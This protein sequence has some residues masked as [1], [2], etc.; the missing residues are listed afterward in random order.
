MRIDQLTF[1]RFIAAIAIVVYH[2]GAA[3]APF[4]FTA[5]SFLFK[6]ANLGV[7][8]FYVLSGFVMMLAYTDKAPINAKLFLWNRLARIYPIYILALLAVCIFFFFVHAPINS[9]DFILSLLC[10]QAW[11]PSA[12][13]SINKP[14]WSISVEALFYILFPFILNRFYALKTQIP[15]TVTGIIIIFLLSQFGFHYF[16]HAYPIHTHQELHHFVYYF[17]LWHVNEFLIGTL[18]GWYFLQQKK[19][20][21]R[22]YDLSI[23]FLFALLVVLLKYPLGM[24]Y[25]NGLMAVLFAPLLFIMSANTGIVTSILTKRPLIFLGEISYGIYVLQYP[26]FIMGNKLGK[27]IGFNAAPQFFYFNLLLLIGVASLSYLYFEKPMRKYL[28]KFIKA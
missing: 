25:H 2:Y 20:A 11:V 17:P 8:F 12:A 16:L 23:L 13:L 28:L 9:K 6:Q 14:G 4:H 19:Q 26:I 7:S 15:Y 22:N 27:W 24:N 18:C 1:L 10:L 5:I 3:I 21:A